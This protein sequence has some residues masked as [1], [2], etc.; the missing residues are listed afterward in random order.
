MTLTHVSLKN[1]HH[2]DLLAKAGAE[3]QMSHTIFEYVP[4]CFVSVKSVK[5]RNPISGISKLHRMPL[6][7]VMKTHTLTIFGHVEGLICVNMVF[8]NVPSQTVNTFL[9]PP[10]LFI[11][12]SKQRN[13]TLH[14]TKN[15]PTSITLGINP[16]EINFEEDKTRSWFLFLKIILIQ[17]PT[18]QV[19]V[20]FQYFCWR[21]YAHVSFH[22]FRYNKNFTFSKFQ[23]ILSVPDVKVV[24]YLKKNGNKYENFIL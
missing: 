19:F 15:L 9:I 23:H 3:L 16:S 12:F 21:I 2:L 22:I 4:L 10:P 13:Q 20:S 17:A 7:M 1:F 5:N 8:S 11:N 14:L 18:R 24:K 6:G